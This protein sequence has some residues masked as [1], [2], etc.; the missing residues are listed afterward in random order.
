MGSSESGGQ[1]LIDVTRKV[2]DVVD[3]FD[4]AFMAVTPSNDEESAVEA[5]Y[6]KAYESIYLHLKHLVLRRL[7]LLVKNLIMKNIQPYLLNHRNVKRALFV[8]NSKLGGNW[9]INLFVL[10]W[11][12]SRHK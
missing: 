7:K 5:E 4:R 1:A 3:N 11:L 12:L 2:L 6:K 9:V 10:L 8:N